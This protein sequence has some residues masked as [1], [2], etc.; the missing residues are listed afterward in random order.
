M[1]REYMLSQ[2][3]KLWVLPK[4][5]SLVDA[6]YEDV[7]SGVKGKY[8]DLLQH[9][10]AE[11]EH[12][13]FAQPDFEGNTNGFNADELRSRA[14]RFMRN[15][16]GPKTLSMV[17]SF[18]RSGGAA[19]RNPFTVTCPMELWAKTNK[20]ALRAQ[21]CAELD[22]PN[23]AS[24]A[25][26]HHPAFIGTRKKVLKREFD[27]LPE[28]EKEIYYEAVRERREDLALTGM[29]PSTVQ[30]RQL[31]FVDWFNKEIHKKMYNGRLGRTMLVEYSGFYIGEE[32]RRVHRFRGQTSSYDTKLWCNTADFKENVEHL[33]DSFVD[34]EARVRPGASGDE[35][36]AAREELKDYFELTF[37]SLP[38]NK[39]VVQCN[40]AELD[41]DAFWEDVEA[42]TIDFVSPQRIP[43]GIRFIDPMQMPEKDFVVLQEH[44]Y[45]SQQKRRKVPP[46]SRFVYEQAATYRYIEIDQAIGRKRTLG[47]S[48]EILGVPIY[49]GPGHLHPPKMTR[50]AAQSRAV[51]ERKLRV[52]QRGA[53][54][55]LLG[56]SLRSCIN[57][58][59]QKLTALLDL[60]KTSPEWRPD[61][62]AVK[63]RP[64]S[65]LLHPRN[66]AVMIL[67]I[68][69]RSF[70]A[71]GPKKRRLPVNQK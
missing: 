19:E 8:R 6:R 49:K 59:A 3:F 25:V 16:T 21:I 51:R 5:R 9:Y 42:N 63:S 40:I 48:Q 43:T 71:A 33:W 69:R 31:A 61:L 13:P 23:D 1:P 54:F 57:P 30:E 56:L 62:R 58:Q 12:Q 60:S 39:F 52:P 68:L 26:T 55:L 38:A 70:P 47:E 18:E 17:T 32:D 4:L 20:Q 65:P 45:N 28:T 29:T 41:E 37:K 14:K 64:S 66:G 27:A 36:H 34:E 10:M 35:L 2:E 50:S 11:Y 22:V 44:V 67:R 24:D 46:G 7:R 53:P 15:H